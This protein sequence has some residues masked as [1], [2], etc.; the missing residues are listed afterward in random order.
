MPTVWE[1]SYVDRLQVGQKGAVQKAV[2]DVRRA[3]EPLIGPD[4][5]K[6]LAAIAT[7]VMMSIQRRNQRA[8]VNDAC[9]ALRT[10]IAL[11]EAVDPS[12]DG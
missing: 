3:I 1:N 4:A 12:L 5:V 7:D 2:D 10:A 9:A 6:V 8:D 11:L